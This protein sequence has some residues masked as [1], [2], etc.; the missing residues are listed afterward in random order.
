VAR[1]PATLRDWLLG[2]EAKRLLLRALLAEPSR[3][4][5]KS[6]LARAARVGVYGGVDKHVAALV[7]LGLLHHVHGV[8]RLSAE[9]ELVKPLRALLEILDRVPQSTVERR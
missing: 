9:H 8:W 5:T 1:K 6:D 7:Q 3:A 2:S 4:W